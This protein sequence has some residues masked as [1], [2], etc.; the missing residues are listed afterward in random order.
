MAFFCLFVPA[1]GQGK[2]IGVFLFWAHPAAYAAGPGFP[3]QF[4]DPRHL[5]HPICVSQGRR[6]SRKNACRVCLRYLRYFVSVIRSGREFQSQFHRNEVS[7]EIGSVSRSLPRPCDRLCR[8]IW[9]GHSDG[10]RYEVGKWL[11]VCGISA[12]IPC[13]GQNAPRFWFGIHAGQAALFPQNLPLDLFDN[14]FY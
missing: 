3:L 2:R 13:A 12:S 1:A 10:G 9:A 5:P 6:K 4:L 14:L 8:P 7:D 11:G